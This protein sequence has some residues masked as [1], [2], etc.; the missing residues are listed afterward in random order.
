MRGSPPPPAR[1]TSPATLPTRPLAARAQGCGVV[2]MSTRQEAQ[3]IMDALDGKATLVRAIWRSSDLAAAIRL[4]AIW[5]S[6]RALC[7]LR[8]ARYT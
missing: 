6:A 7:G 4:A 5:I 3:A 2:T 1:P 8:G